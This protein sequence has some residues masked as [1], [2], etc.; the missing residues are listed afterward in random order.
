MTPNP[1]FSSVLSSVLGTSL[2]FQYQHEYLVFVCI[3]QAWA[4]IILI[5]H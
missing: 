1:N 2:F 5:P 4:L 3:L